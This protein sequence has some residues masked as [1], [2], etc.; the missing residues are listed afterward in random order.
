MEENKDKEREREREQEREWKKKC[1]INAYKL[2]HAL[3]TAKQA[4]LFKLR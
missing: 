1:N 4:F 2:K 3:R